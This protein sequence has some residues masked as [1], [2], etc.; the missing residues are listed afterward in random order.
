MLCLYSNISASYLLF[1]YVLLCFVYIVI[2]LLVI[3]YVLLCFGYI[4][5][6]ILLF[7]IFYLDMYSYAYFHIHVVIILLIIFYLDMSYAYF[8][9]H[10]VILLL[11]IYLD[12]YCC[13][14]FT[15]L[16][17]EKLSLFKK[18]TNTNCF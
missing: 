6:V 16:I 15:L 13:A 11:I 10:V 8:D 2:I 14:L 1:G 4:H 9:K 7:I 3:I 5:V 17:G 18:C 12:I